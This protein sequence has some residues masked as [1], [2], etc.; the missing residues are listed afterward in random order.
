MVSLQDVITRLGQL[1]YE[2]PAG[3]NSA[4]QFE[5]DWVLDYTVNYCN[6]SSR[7]EIP[8]LLD[9]RIIDRVCGEYLFKQQKAGNL[10]GFDYSAFVKTIKEGDTQLQF[11]N[12]SDGETPESRFIDLCNRLERGFDKW[13]THFRRIKW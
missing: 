10:E 7:D 8:T 13:L 6:F 2:V 12:S 9:K 4:V 11:G 1:G 3:G 5:L